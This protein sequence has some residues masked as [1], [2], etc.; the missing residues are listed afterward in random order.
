MKTLNQISQS[1]VNKVI[2]REELNGYK[3]LKKVAEQ[4]INAIG[5]SDPIEVFYTLVFEKK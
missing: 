1:D 2:L 5:N 4:T 3:F